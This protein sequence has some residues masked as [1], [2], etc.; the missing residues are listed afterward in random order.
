M[1]SGQQLERIYLQANINPPE[2][3]QLKLVAEKS[4]TPINKVPFEKLRSFNIANHKGCIAVKSK[5]HYQDLQ[6][7][8]SHVVEKVG[9]L[10]FFYL[11]VLPI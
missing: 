4:G 1:N 8:I 11:M 5:V 9:F 6:D 10:F 7:V 3:D 2:A